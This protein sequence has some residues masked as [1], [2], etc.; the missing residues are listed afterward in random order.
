MTMFIVSLGFM[1]VAVCLF[2]AMAL[3]NPDRTP[4]GLAR[5]ARHP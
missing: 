1:T 2:V 5:R 3:Q 4:A